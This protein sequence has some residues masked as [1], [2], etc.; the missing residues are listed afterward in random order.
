VFN[1]DA[2]GQEKHDLVHKKLN[3]CY[4][5]IK[6]PDFSK[7]AAGFGASGYDVSPPDDFAEL[8]KALRVEEG[9][10][11]VNVRINGQVE[12]PISWEIAQHL[13]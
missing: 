7:L 5:D 1:D 3:P 10:V 12:L 6:Q 4:A 11:I 13:S 2:V 9:P 8:D